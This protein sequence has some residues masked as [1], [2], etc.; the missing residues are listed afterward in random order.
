MPAVDTDGVFLPDKKK[1]ALLEDQLYRL[2]LSLNTPVVE[3]ED[4]P[5]GPARAA[6]LVHYDPVV[7]GVTTTVGI[8]SLKDGT[9]VYYRYQAE[10]SDN[11]PFEA[12]LDTGLAFT[13][14]MGFLFDDEE[15]HEVDSKDQA[16]ALK[17]FWELM[18]EPT[19]SE[20]AGIDEDPDATT[21]E[22]E[23]GEVVLDL[24]TEASV[25]EDEP[26]AEPE[27]L[28][29]EETLE[30][31]LEMIDDRDSGASVAV[32]TESTLISDDAEPVLDF[33]EDDSTIR[34]VVP[35]ESF[36]DTDPE[37]PMEAQVADPEPSFAVEDDWLE[38]ESEVLE[39]V[40]I[41]AEAPEAVLTATEA[42][43]PAEPIAAEA[44]DPAE[45]IVA[46][47]QDD[48]EPIAAEAPDPAEP[49]AAEAPDPA[50]SIAARAPVHGLT[51][52][53]VPPDT[54]V[55]E[56]VDAAEAPSLESA[57][58]EPET[59]EPDEQ[60]AIGRRAD[61]PK[62]GPQALGRLRLVKRRAQLPT[63]TPEEPMNPIERLLGSF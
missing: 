44:L 36:E 58:A 57:T 62:T 37:P 3:T 51:K 54:S 10:I 20:S 31:P 4:L 7:E 18:G 63:E 16:R 17:L 50:E 27:L 23:L 34:V 40:P 14:T 21:A 2:R 60:P 32:D 55:T 24:A 11:Q 56:T 45:P 61:D 39:A 29:E 19:G 12:A 42:L 49:I 41:A 52:F 33:G 46:E 6:L 47:A 59:V 8:R 28:L 22:I 26:H 1:P 38:S 15:I 5:E 35:H 53:R 25:V 13:E 9:V 30:A 43:D 48:A